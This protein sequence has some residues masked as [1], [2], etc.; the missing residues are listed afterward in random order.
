MSKICPCPNPPGGQIV[1]EDNQFGMCGYEDG[2][3]IGGCLN[4]P[5]AISKIEDRRQRTIA[6]VNWILS[7]LTGELRSAT[8]ELGPTQLDML[9]SGMATRDGVV[10][11]FNLP[12]TIDLDDVEGVKVNVAF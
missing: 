10:F 9:R 4:V 1:C 6:T 11:H 12:S 7:E 5:Y 3:R 2:K 8:D